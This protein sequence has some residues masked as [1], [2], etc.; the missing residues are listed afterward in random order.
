MPFP[1]NVLRVVCALCL[2][3]LTRGICTHTADTVHTHNRGYAEPRT[4]QQQKSTSQAH[5]VYLSRVICMLS[6][7]VC[8]YV[9]NVYN[10][11]GARSK[12]DLLR[13]ARA[14]Y[15]STMC[16][17]SRCEQSEIYGTYWLTLLALFWEMFKHYADISHNTFADAIMPVV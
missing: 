12:R 7:I 14:A 4:A 2:R 5:E 11:F 15:T 1:P 6:Y 10:M 17:A 9:C 3:R 13:L 8:I 16:T